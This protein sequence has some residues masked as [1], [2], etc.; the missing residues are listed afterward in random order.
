[1]NENERSFAPAADG[2]SAEMLEE[3]LA[4]CKKRIEELHGEIGKAYC[5]AA[6]DAPLPENKSVTPGKMVGLRVGLGTDISGGS[7]LDMADAVRDALSASRLLWRLSEEHP[8]HL[9]LA[10][11]FSLATAGGGAFFGKAGRFEPG[12]EFDAVA[13]DDSPWAWPGD[14]LPIRFQKMLYRARSE[15]VTAKYVSGEKLF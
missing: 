8:P 15:N 5:L 3:K 7:S 6:G 9:A 13:V 4:Q 2:A 10:E 12:Y 14:E 1:M 11:A